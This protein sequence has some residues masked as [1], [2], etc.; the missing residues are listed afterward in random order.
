MIKEENTR[1]RFTPTGNTAV[2]VLPQGGE[3]RDSQGYYI[4]IHEI[5]ANAK[6]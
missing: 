5:L 3:G 4:D 6:Y 1:A 2:Y